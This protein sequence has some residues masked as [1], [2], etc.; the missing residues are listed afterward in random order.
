MSFGRFF[1]PRIAQNRETW[2][3]YRAARRGAERE[4]SEARAA[5]EVGMPSREKVV[6]KSSCS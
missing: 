2:E 1:S 3:N 5:A 6:V 4:V